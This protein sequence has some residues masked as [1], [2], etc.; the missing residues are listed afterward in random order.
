MSSLVILE[1]GITRDAG[2]PGT[3]VPLALP[4]LIYFDK[5]VLAAA[6]PSGYCGFCSLSGYGR[7]TS[8]CFNLSL[9]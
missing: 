1:G 4:D 9:F 6:E 5:V 3:V 7:G 2:L 8:G